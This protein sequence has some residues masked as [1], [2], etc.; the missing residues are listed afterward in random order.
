LHGETIQLTESMHLLGKGDSCVNQI[1]RIGATAY[2]IQAHFELNEG[3]LESWIAE[4]PDL[5]KL[6]A[7]QLRADFNLLKSG[8]PQ[9]GRQ[10]FTNFIKIAGLIK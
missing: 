9:T 8:Y 10:L 3:L 1:V 6:D 5:Q 4:D 2:G 7:E